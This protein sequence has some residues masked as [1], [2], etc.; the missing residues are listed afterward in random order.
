[1]SNAEVE[2][3]ERGKALIYVVRDR[4]CIHLGGIPCRLFETPTMQEQ[5]IRYGIRDTLHE[6]SLAITFIIMD[7]LQRQ[8]TGRVVPCP[9]FSLLLFGLRV[10]CGTVCAQVTSTPATLDIRPRDHRYCMVSCTFLRA[11]IAAGKKDA[12]AI[13][14]RK[15]T[16]KRLRKT[17][18]INGMAVALLSRFVVVYGIDQVVSS[19]ARN[20]VEIVEDRRGSS[21][22][23]LE[24][25]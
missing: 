17:V 9:L 21:V 5:E 8:Y 15:M 6:L 2:S 24:R 12:Q 16:P 19:S 18:S 7:A 10:F 1:M 23:P 20:G 13:P 25:A 4:Y 22:Q 14:T 11:F 3:E